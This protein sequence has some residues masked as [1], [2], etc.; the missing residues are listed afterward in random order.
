MLN[1]WEILNVNFTL[2]VEITKQKCSI[3]HVEM[4]KSVVCD[5]KKRTI[6]QKVMIKKPNSVPHHTSDANMHSFIFYSTEENTNKNVILFYL[7]ILVFEF[8]RQF[9][10]L[11]LLIPYSHKTH[12]NQLI[13]VI[14]MRNEHFSRIAAKKVFF[15]SS[16][17][18]SK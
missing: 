10:I 4:L 17:N 6:M 15:L 7:Y 16:F 13:T 1:A 12:V 8:E 11:T 18:I 14:V 3:A 2:P 9:E 5:P